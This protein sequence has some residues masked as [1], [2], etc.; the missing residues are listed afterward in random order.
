MTAH[1]D[2]S[3][4]GLRLLDLLTAPEAA[5]LLTRALGIRYSAVMVHRLANEDPPLLERVR[6]GALVRYTPESAAAYA[7]KLTAAAEAAR[8]EAARPS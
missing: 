2:M 8:A 6:F 1:D 5:I 3:A 4:A 7:Q